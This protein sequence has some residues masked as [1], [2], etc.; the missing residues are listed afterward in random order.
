MKLYILLLTALIITGCKNKDVTDDGSDLSETAQQVGD[1]MA[2]I[3]EAGG[4]GGSISNYNKYI[5][6]TFA[7][8]SPENA[9]TKFEI[10]QALQPTAQATPCAGTGFA[11]CATGS[12]TRTFNSCTVGQATFTGT[13]TLTWTGAMASTCALANPND[14]I[15]R[16]PNITVTG[17]RSASLAIT[18]TA[19]FGQKLTWTSTNGGGNKIF[20][21]DNDGI[22]RKFTV[23]SNVLFNQTTTTITPLTITGGPRAGRVV[24]GGVLRVSNLLTSVNCD[25]IPAAVTWTA[26]CNCP[27]SGTWNGS[28]STGKTSTLVITGCGTGTYTE[29]SATSSVS[30]D[31]CGT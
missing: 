20:S 16:A 7:K 3:D 10:I 21:F 19:S 27:T 31:R 1:V 12:V 26:G 9:P 13:V 15:T 11:G 5:Q 18:K 30:F 28:C 14:T 22:N 8:Y 29:D 2:S 6:K 25:Y 4:S 23:G 17:R 24:S